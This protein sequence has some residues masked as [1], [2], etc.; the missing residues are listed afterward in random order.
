MTHT[1]TNIK[2][3][4]AVVFII[5]NIL[6]LKIP[7]VKKNNLIFECKTIDIKIYQRLSIKKRKH[8]QKVLRKYPW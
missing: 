7:V 6:H 2:V 5:D 1:E 4:A 8:P 3:F